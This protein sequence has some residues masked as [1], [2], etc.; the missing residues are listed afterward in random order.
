MPLSNTGIAGRS[1]MYGWFSPLAVSLV[2]LPSFGTSFGTSFCSTQWKTLHRRV[3][4][5]SSTLNLHW[6][7]KVPGSVSTIQLTICFPSNFSLLYEFRCLVRLSFLAKHFPQFLH[8]LGIFPLCI[9]ECEFKFFFWVNA[10]PH[11]VHVKGFTLL[12]VT[13][14]LVRFD[15]LEKPNLTNRT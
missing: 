4:S 15:F 7:C 12:W 8:L 5:G 9:M 14:C 1:M 13:M 11:S 3:S 2:C 10:T 6:S